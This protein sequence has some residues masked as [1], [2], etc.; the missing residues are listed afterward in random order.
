LSRP[1]AREARPAQASGLGV[2]ESRTFEIGASIASSRPRATRRPT[3]RR[4]R[5]RRALACNAIPTL[6]S[7]TI[8]RRTAPAVDRIAALDRKCRRREGQASA[9]SP[10]SRGSPR[11]G[12]RPGDD[13]RAAAEP[14][15]PRRPTGR[16]RQPGRCAQHLQPVR[17]GDPPRS[18]RPRDPARPPDGPGPPSGN[19]PRGIV[20]LSGRPENDQVS[21]SIIEAVRHIEDVVAVW[22]QLGVAD[23]HLYTATS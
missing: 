14:E 5:A 7:S 2:E 22:D 11:P 8:T 13:D 10:D 1:A 23:D 4:S 16:D 21:R 6:H 19:R 15:R 20:T 18:D 12:A 17:R 9:D 3:S